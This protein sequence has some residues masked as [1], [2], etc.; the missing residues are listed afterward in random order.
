MSNNYIVEVVKEET[1][2][3]T[4][5][6]ENTVQVIPPA[7][8]SV[9]ISADETKISVQQDVTSVEVTAPDPITV[10]ISE[11]IKIS[12]SATEAAKLVFTKTLT[13]DT[14]AFQMVRLVSNTHVDL[15]DDSTLAESS[16]IGI[17]LESKLA[18]EDVRILT[19][20][21]AEDPSFTYGI[22]VKLFLGEN[23]AI[24]DTPTTTVGEF[25]TPIGEGLGTGAIFIK[26]EEPEGIV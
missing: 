13:Q 25:V 22:N 12:S 2:V 26:I 19:F 8:P 6:A 10:E 16:A 20:G 5:A 1:S 18:G 3:S 14:A 4:S 7:S 9:D 11:A 21:I 15:C 23:G 24:T 17:T